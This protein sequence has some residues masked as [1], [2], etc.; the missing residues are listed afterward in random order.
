M[1][2]KQRT[3]KEADYRA[4]RWAAVLELE[5]RNNVR[6]GIIPERVWRQLYIKG[7][8]AAGC[9]RPSGDV[10]LQQAIGR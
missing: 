3:A 1:P 6:A 5:Q 2:T 8:D 4:W 9:S 10:G 7:V